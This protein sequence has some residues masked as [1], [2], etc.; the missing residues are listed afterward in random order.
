MFFEEV[1]KKLN[2]FLVV[3]QTDQPMAPFLVET[4]DGVIRFFLEKFMLKAVMDKSSSPLSLTKIDLCETAK[5]KPASLADLGFAINHEISLLKSKK[6]TTD[7][8][9]TKFKKE[10]V[11]FLS[12]MCS[13][14]IQKKSCILFCQMSD[15]FISSLHCGATRECGVRF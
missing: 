5:Q 13:H 8:Q 4:L 11:A 2:E 3:F 9:I 14:L 12:K 7:S 15:M 1:A 10:A 6:L